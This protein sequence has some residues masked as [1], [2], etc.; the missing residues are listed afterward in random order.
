MTEGG[1]LHWKIQKIK[2]GNGPP[3]DYS[4]ILQPLPDPPKGMIWKKDEMTGEW[5]IV[6]KE[7]TSKIP[8]NNNDTIK[9]SYIDKSKLDNG[10]DDE[11]ELLDVDENGSSNH[12]VTKKT[13]DESP[14]PK[15]EEVN[16]VEHLVL[17]T[18]T[19]EGICLNYKISPTKLRQANRFSG[20][21]LV[22]APKKLKIPIDGKNIIEMKT[23]DENSNEYKIHTLINEFPD[24]S[25]SEAKAYLEISEW[26]ISDARKDAKDD[27]EWELKHLDSTKKCGM[28]DHKVHMEVHEGVPVATTTGSTLKTFTQTELEM[29]PLL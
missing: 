18:D 6:E 4:Q 3:A 23:Q 5:S 20:S 19:F 15:Y 24:L 7:N 2:Y 13:G 8:L 12:K 28:H 9:T 25:I 26:K 16:Y 17:P 21:N 14:P 1:L 27:R 29:S 10:E 22:L 11:W